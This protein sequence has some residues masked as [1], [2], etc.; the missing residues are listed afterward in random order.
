MK[1]N[2]ENDY[3][4][5]INEINKINAKRKTNNKIKR[6]R[7]V[8]SSSKIN[9]SISKT[10]YLF[11]KN[12]ANNTLNFDD[13]KNIVLEINNVSII[14]WDLYNNSNNIT[15]K[16]LNNLFNDTD[17]ITYIYDKALFDK[18]IRKKMRALLRKRKR[19]SKMNKY[20]NSLLVVI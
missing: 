1:N 3:V 16:N 9:N 7:K 20:N 8:N 17:N 13:F 14:R 4:K 18:I 2:F 5:S 6:N 19:M 15:Y 12:I 10:K 11:N